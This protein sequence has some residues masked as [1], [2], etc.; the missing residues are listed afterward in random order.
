MTRTLLTIWKH[1]PFF[2]KITLGALAALCSILILWWFLSPPS[3]WKTHY[4]QAEPVHLHILIS[5]SVQSHNEV[6][7]LSPIEGRIEKI[8]HEEG[9]HVE[10][11]Q[12]IA[13]IGTTQR[14][15]LLDKTLREKPNDLSSVDQTYPPSPVSS[16]ITGK[17]VEG[18]LS[19]GTSVL[20][21]SPLFRISD[22]F[23]I[24]AHINEADLPYIRKGTPASISF[25]AFPHHHIPGTVD[26]VAHAAKT[27]GNVVAYEVEI[28]L[29]QQPDFLRLGLTAIVT[30]T[31]SSSPE[32]VS[33]PIEA[34]RYKDNTPHVL[35]LRWFLFAEWVPV[36]TGVSNGTHIEI[37]S[38]LAPGDTLRIPTSPLDDS[39][40]TLRGTPF[41]TP[42][43]N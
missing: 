2:T 28:S 7:V 26:Y 14:S 3:G 1:T 36:K 41:L 19:I 35:R 16:P 43:Q 42:P 5:G 11:G 22:R 31:I 25:E 6:T 34:I 20:H 40:T 38:G 27:L 32:H 10:K 33:V 9:S 13:F 21:N 37:T 4:A 39:D 8:P 30:F 12:V 24:Q 17:I 18:R 23:V 15:F 29:S